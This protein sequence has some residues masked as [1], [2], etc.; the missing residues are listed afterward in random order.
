MD[1]NNDFDSQA[2]TLVLGES[3]KISPKSPDVGSSSPTPPLSLPHVQ[4]GK[5]TGGVSVSKVI[6][7]SH[8]KPSVPKK[9]VMLDGFKKRDSAG[10]IPPTL[11][12][13]D[14]GSRDFITRQLVC[15]YMDESHCNFAVGL[16]CDTEPW[17]DFYCR[18]I[19]KHGLEPLPEI[20]EL[21][22]NRATTSSDSTP[23][24]PS[25]SSTFRRQNA[26]FFG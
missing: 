19:R 17:F 10:T 20:A 21:F 24:Q 12:H 15:Q 13:S 3:P 11:T 1:A 14:P 8:L 6:K 25:N 9:K 7:E 5:S 2:T 18:E 23:G 26:S 16:A 22:P 4:K